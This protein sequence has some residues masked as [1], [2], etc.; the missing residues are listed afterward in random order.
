M[1]AIAIK[2]LVADRGKLLTALVG[3]VFSIVLVNVQGGLF[4]GLISKASL[5]VD[6]GGADIWV[7]HKKMN[8]V[9]FPYDIPRRWVQRIRSIEGVKRAEPYLVGHSVMT[10]PDGGFE[11]VLVVGSEPLSLLG[12]ANNGIG[13]ASLDRPMA[14]WSTIA[15]PKKLAIHNWA[16]SV[17]LAIAGPVLL[18]SAMAFS[19]FW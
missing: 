12:S 11:Q 4:I 2:T 15:K 18:V 3:V 8:N 14:S 5:L 9:D 6:Q 19:V 7:G 10:L 1:W 13:A 17:K 16:I